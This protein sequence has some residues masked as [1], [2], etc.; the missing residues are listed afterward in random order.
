MVSGI[1][2]EER[3]TSVNVVPN[4]KNI[5]FF[6]FF[7]HFRS[8]CLRPRFPDSDV[9]YCGIAMILDHSVLF[10]SRTNQE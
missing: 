2:D 5:Y 8:S 4:D 9:L 6:F 3:I 7:L 10:T 1:E